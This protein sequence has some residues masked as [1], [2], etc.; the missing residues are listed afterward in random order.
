MVKDD[1]FVKSFYQ[2]FIKNSSQKHSDEI[3]IRSF[4][5]NLGIIFKGT[6]EEKLKCIIRKIFLHYKIYVSYI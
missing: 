3:D 5:L 4:L 2:T 6:V 1:V